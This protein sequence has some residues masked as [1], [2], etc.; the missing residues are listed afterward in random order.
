MS[1]V[2]LVIMLAGVDVFSISSFPRDTPAVEVEVGVDTHE[3]SSTCIRVFI[4]LFYA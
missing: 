4:M 3:V 1:L 2:S